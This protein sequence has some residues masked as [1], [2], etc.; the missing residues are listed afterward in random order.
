MRAAVALWVSARVWDVGAVCR[1][2][3]HGAPPSR[4]G[5]ARCRERVRRRRLRWWCASAACEAGTGCRP[6]RRASSAEHS[7]VRVHTR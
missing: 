7:R 6:L 5:P 4:L 1:W 3:I 2:R